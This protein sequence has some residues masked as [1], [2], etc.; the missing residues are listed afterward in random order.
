MFNNIYRTMSQLKL[1]LTNCTC[2]YQLIKLAKV[3]HFFNALD[4]YNSFHLIYLHFIPS[5]HKYQSKV[6]H[7]F[8]A[9]YS[10]LASA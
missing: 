7:F 10:S 2:N 9:H 3:K 8:L 4:K 1:V 5:N 6:K